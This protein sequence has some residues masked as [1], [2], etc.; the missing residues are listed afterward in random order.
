MTSSVA[1]PVLPRS[2]STCTSPAANRSL[3][4]RAGE[5]H[6]GALPVIHGLGDADR[7]LP[8][9]AAR[10]VEHL[11]T[12]VEQAAELAAR[13]AASDID[14]TGRRR[15]PD[16]QVGGIVRVRLRRELHGLRPRTSAWPVPTKTFSAPS[17]CSTVD[18]AM[19]VDSWSS[20]RSRSSS[21]SFGGCPVRARALTMRSFRSAR[22]VASR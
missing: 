21:R 3:P 22:L 15:D 8:E 20:S 19:R 2:A 17:S 12:E 5:V 6:A 7:Q 11:A 13:D 18:T 14:E 16:P 10:R 1:L 4:D 9:R